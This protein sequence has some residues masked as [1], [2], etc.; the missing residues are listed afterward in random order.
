[1]VVPYLDAVVLTVLF[2]RVSP[3]VEVPATSVA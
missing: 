3:A 2:T 1:M